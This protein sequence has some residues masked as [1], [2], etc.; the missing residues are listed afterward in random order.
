[1]TWGKLHIEVDDSG[2]SFP[3]L[4][5]YLKPKYY[6]FFWEFKADDDPD[7]E[8][9]L[10]T[11]HVLSDVRDALEAI[12]WA[13]THAQGR[14]MATFV[15]FYE[16]RADGGL[17]NL[18]KVYGIIPEGRLLEE[19]DIF[20]WTYYPI[21]WPRGAIITAEEIA[22]VDKQLMERDFPPDL[23]RLLDRRFSAALDIANDWLTQPTTEH[24]HQL[25]I[26]CYFGVLRD[27][28]QVLD[29]DSGLGLCGEVE[30]LFLALMR[31]SAEDIEM[32]TTAV[33]AALDEAEGNITAAHLLALT[34]A[35][36][37]LGDSLGAR[38][39]TFLVEHPMPESW[40]KA[41]THH[42]DND[43]EV[44]FQLLWEARKQYSMDDTS[45]LMLLIPWEILAL[46]VLRLKKN[47]SVAG[48]NQP[49]FQTYL[50]ILEELDIGN[51][52]PAWQQEL[53]TAISQHYDA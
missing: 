29:R 53:K 5:Q 48:I 31:E 27:Y 12:D 33:L 14:E 40:Q 22:A 52:V 18:V 39:S 37:Y 38:V 13:Q 20:E 21:S 3:Y 16:D 10:Q 11:K 24:F 9:W 7:W 50:A 8:Y 32:T 43:P 19:D 23:A 46:C 36:N 34:L 25:L 15:S 51:I 49:E 28:V 26:T 17:D 2:Y 30:T 47:L 35:V 45:L 4:E 1:M 44:F 6:V 42:L 41:Y